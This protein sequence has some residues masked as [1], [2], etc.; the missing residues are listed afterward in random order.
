MSEQLHRFIRQIKT[1]CPLPNP[2]SMLTQTKIPPYWVVKVSL[3]QMHLQAS[4]LSFFAVVL[5]HI[6]PTGL[7]CAT[8]TFCR[9]YGMRPPFRIH[10]QCSRKQK[11]HPIGWY[12]CLVGAGGFGPPKSVTTDLQ[13]APFG[14]S[15]TLPYLICTSKRWSWWTDSNPRPADYKSA[16]LPAELHQRDC[17][18]HA[19]LSL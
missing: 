12:F 3:F 7:K 8:G 9:A 18:S 1:R 6:K 10:F 15:G 19:T 16:A 13:S 4:A 2:L 5:T 17:S 11:Y 14:R